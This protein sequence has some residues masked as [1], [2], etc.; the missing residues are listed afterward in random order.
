MVGINGGRYKGGRYKRTCVPTQ[1]RLFADDCLIYRTIKSIHDQVQMQKDLD[2]LQ[3]WGE[4]WSMKFNASKC[5]ILTVS[6]L[7]NPITK[8]DQLNNTILPRN[9]WI[10]LLI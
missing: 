8:F 4:L 7:E 10:V 3:L 6:N 1:V 2:A 9:M 5:N